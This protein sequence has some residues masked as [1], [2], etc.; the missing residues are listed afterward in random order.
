MPFAIAG[1]WIAVI[2]AMLS[3][4]LDRTQADVLIHMDPRDSLTFLE[5]D[6]TNILD[7][8][9]QHAAIYFPTWSREDRK[10]IVPTGEGK[11]ENAATH[12]F[13]VFCETSGADDL[14]FKL[15][16]EC[17]KNCPY[18]HDV[19]VSFGTLP[20]ENFV[21]DGVLHYGCGVVKVSFASPAAFGQISSHACL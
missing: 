7:F 17:G 3:C 9:I 6:L 20:G 4:M 1:T 21:E 18:D 13:D 10:K 5:P 15:D 8:G 14:A 2:A 16:K 11:K 19:I 12:D